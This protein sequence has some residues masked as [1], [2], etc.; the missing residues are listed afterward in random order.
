MKRSQSGLGQRAEPGA[1]LQEGVQGV[2]KAWGGGQGGGSGGSY[3]AQG[4]ELGQCSRPGCGTLQAIAR[5]SPTK[6]PWGMQGAPLPRG[7]LDTR[8]EYE[9]QK[10]SR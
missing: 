4:V 7:S 9:P 10:R 5:R 6:L 8:S 1:W 2:M 3:P